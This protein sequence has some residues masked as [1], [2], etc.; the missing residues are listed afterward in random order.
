MLL[1]VQNPAPDS[2]VLGLPSPF[3][4]AIGANATRETNAG[5][6]FKSSDGEAWIRLARLLCE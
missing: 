2:V 4:E 5:M 3:S 1:K 6:V